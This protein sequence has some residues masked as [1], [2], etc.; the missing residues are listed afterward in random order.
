[1]GIE[2]S[3]M[4]K[5]NGNSDLVCKKCS[6][7]IHTVK[8]DQT[9]QIDGH[10]GHYVGKLSLNDSIDANFGMILKYSEEWV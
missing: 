4:G 7:Y 6:S 3:H 1:M 9:V 5:N 8:T 2:L 10:T